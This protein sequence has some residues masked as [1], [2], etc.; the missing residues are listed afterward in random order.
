MRKERD[1]VQGEEGFENLIIDGESPGLS[2]SIRASLGNWIKILIGIL[3]LV[4][5]NPLNES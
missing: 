1:D 3:G 2:K 5:C 4:L